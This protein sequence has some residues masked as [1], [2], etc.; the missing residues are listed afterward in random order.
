MAKEVDGRRL[1]WA[2]TKSSGKCDYCGFVIT[3]QQAVGRR[4][5]HNGTCSECGI[6]KI[7]CTTP[8]K[9]DQEHCRHHRWQDELS[10]AT[11]FVAVRREEGNR[12]GLL[13][14]L[15]PSVQK[16]FVEA[17]N[18]PRLLSLRDDV[19]LFVTRQGILAERL[20]TG[21]SGAM[22]RML[23]ELKSEFEGA[24][25]ELSEARNSPDLESTSD[26]VHSM[27]IQR[28]E[29]AK[30]RIETSLRSI[31]RVIDGANE[32]EDAWDELLTLTER[33]VELKRSQHQRLRDLKQMLTAEQATHLVGA[34][35]S[36]V[37]RVVRD[38]ATLGEIESG[39]ADVLRL[40]GPARL[41]SLDPSL[42]AP[43]DPGTSSPTRVRPTPP[44]AS[45]AS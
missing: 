4:I 2:V 34:L 5:K 33:T 18:D 21:E 28:V 10:G 15:P 38:R 23:L 27:A 44:D 20:D 42:A 31:M 13:Q 1:C 30:K 7:R 9:A 8:I 16:L 39:L 24:N 11:K 17:Y 40:P 6:G 36:V 45:G 32:R 35:V 26:A 25:R 19:A 3:P 41:P 12:R 43:S 22:W 29:S 37:R 14:H